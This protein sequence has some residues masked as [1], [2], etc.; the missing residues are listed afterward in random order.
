MGC[1]EAYARAKLAAENAGLTLGYVNSVQMVDNFISYFDMQEQIDTLPQKD[2]EGQLDA[3]CSEIAAR[4]TVEVRI[5]PITKAQMALYQ[6][7]LPGAGCGRTRPSP[8]RSMTAAF[9]AASASKSARPT[10]SR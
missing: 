5:T 10:T 1:G 6:K 9:T 3:V 8:I 2:V 7:R 4:K